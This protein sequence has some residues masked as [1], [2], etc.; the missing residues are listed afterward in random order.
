MDFDDFMNWAMLFI[1][2]FFIFFV[3]RS[4]ST[5]PTLDGICEYKYG[6]N[7]VFV[8]DEFGKYCIKLV[9]EN[10]TRVDPKEYPSDKEIKE[11]CEKT[12]FWKLNDWSRGNCGGGE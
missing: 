11:M 8:H 4:S 10:L 5:S 3:V 9:F 7:Y 2:L 12:P 1:F 6:E